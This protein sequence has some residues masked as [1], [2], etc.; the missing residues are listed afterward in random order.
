MVIFMVPKARENAN[1][2]VHEQETQ[3]KGENCLK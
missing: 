2:K 3:S 1:K